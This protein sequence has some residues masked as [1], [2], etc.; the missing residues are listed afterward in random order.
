MERVDGKD[1]LMELAGVVAP[2]H[3][4]LLVIDVQI[5]D[6]WDK[7][8]KRKN[9]VEKMLTVLQAARKAGVMVIYSRNVRL[10]R[11]CNISGPY[12]RC[13]LKGGYQPGRDPISFLKGSPDIEIVSKIAPRQGELVIDKPRGS[14]FVGTD[15]D[16]ILRSNGILSL[17]LVGGSTDW[18]VEATVWDATGRDYYAVVL[19]DC[20]QGPR[21]DGHGAALKQMA[22]IADVAKAEDVITIWNINTVQRV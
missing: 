16:V 12:L 19:E 18:C 13:L 14:A 1:I 9:A 22:A 11:H 6:S 15:L 5:G 17:V 20:V 3:T 21:P 10:P 8:T 2:K 4:A 7:E